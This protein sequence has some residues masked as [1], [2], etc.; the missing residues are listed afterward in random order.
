MAQRLQAA[1]LGRP[2]SFKNPTTMPPFTAEEQVKRTVQKLSGLLGVS[3]SEI[4]RRAIK[5]GLKQLIRER[6]GELDPMI[7]AAFDEGMRTREEMAENA[8]LELVSDEAFN[9]FVEGWM[10][11]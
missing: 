2:P 4:M 1:P 9:G 6:K 7:R 5:L 3:R 11:A 8:D 10:G